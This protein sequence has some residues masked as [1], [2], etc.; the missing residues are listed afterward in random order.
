M[1]SASYEDYDSTVLVTEWRNDTEKPV[2]FEYHI[3][4]PTPILGRA[5]GSPLTYKERTGNERV[6]VQPGKTISLTSELDQAIQRTLITEDGT[7]IIIAGLAPQLTKLG[8]THE[9][10]LHPAL[11]DALAQRRDALEKAARAM[12]EARTAQDSLLLAQAKIAELEAEK[13]RLETSN[14]P[15]VASAHKQK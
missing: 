7:E 6:V 10:R 14:K 11:D 15:A 12:Q 13:A 8:T 1:Q 9:R 2:R 5:P 4:T 3:Q